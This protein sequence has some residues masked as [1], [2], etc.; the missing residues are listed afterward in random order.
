MMIQ[1]KKRANLRAT[2]TIGS[3][4]VVVQAINDAANK[5]HRPR[6]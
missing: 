6:K 1:L 2:L 3:C 4:A 5:M